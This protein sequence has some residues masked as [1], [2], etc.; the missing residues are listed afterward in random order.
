MIMLDIAGDTKLSKATVLTFKGLIVWEFL[1]WFLSED[2]SRKRITKY[3]NNYRTQR[4]V[5]AKRKRST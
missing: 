2:S 1:L 4:N 5:S 3:K